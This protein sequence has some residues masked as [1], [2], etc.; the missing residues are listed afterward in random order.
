MTNGS[1]R[2]VIVLSVLTVVMVVLAVLP[3]LFIPSIDRGDAT[4]EG[5]FSV[6]CVVCH[7]VE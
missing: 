3:R 5:H 6:G 2:A 1:I 4:P 7:R